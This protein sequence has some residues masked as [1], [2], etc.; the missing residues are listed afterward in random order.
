MPDS[1]NRMTEYLCYIHCSQRPTLKCVFLNLYLSCEGCAE[2]MC[3]FA[4]TPCFTVTCSHNL[5]RCPFQTKPST[6]GRAAAQ[7]GALLQSTIGMCFSLSNICNKYFTDTCC[8][9]PVESIPVMYAAM[10]GQCQSAWEKRNRVRVLCKPAAAAS[11]KNNW[12]ICSGLPDLVFWHS[13]LRWAG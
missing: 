5:K 1:P 4:I 9:G 13:G 2:N 8:L 11:Q 3:S 10:Q 12:N 6:V 7:L